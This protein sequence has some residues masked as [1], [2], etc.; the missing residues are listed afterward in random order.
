M[1]KLSHLVDGE[2]REHGFPAVFSVDAQHAG[3]PRLVSAAPGGD[4]EVFQLLAHCLEPPFYI[5]YVLHTPRGE[6]QA[7]RYQSPLLGI[8]AFDALMT[9]FGALFT[10]DARHDLWMH[11][12]A[13]RATVVWDRHNLVYGYG[14]LDRF[15][16]VLRGLG[17]VPGAVSVD[18]VHMHHY[19]QEYDAL[20]AGLLGELQWSMSPLHPSDEQ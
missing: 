16:N 19:R 8:E 18:F 15:E 4:P 12:P 2:W 13:D 6:S 10:H 14:P 17:F 9:R 5:L 7:G 20:S 1:A 3:V 11:S